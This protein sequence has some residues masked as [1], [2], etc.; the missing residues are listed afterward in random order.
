MS[1]GSLTA[2][3]L[4]ELGLDESIVDS[5]VDFSDL[6]LAKRAAE[7]DVSAFETLYERHIERP[8]HSV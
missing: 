4:L 2:E 7:G 8:I 5:P 6:Q 1:T 3:K